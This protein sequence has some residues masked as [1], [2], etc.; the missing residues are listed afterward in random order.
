MVKCGGKNIHNKDMC[1]KGIGVCAQNIFNILGLVA[2]IVGNGLN[3]H[4]N[5]LPPSLSDLLRAL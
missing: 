2:N 5:L 3:A 1:S 4:L